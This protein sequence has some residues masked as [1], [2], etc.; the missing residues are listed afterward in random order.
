MVA[1]RLDFEIQR[2]DAGI[3]LNDIGLNS[4]CSRRTFELE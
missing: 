4:E 1:S 2:L 3:Q